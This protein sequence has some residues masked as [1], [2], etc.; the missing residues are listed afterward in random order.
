[1]F[2]GTDFVLFYSALLLSVLGKFD[3]SVLILSVRCVCTDSSLFNSAIFM[4]QLVIFVSSLLCSFREYLFDWFVFWK[5]SH[6]LFQNRFFFNCIPNYKRICFTSVRIFTRLFLME[7]N[8]FWFVRI[9]SFLFIAIRAKLFWTLFMTSKN[10]FKICFE[11]FKYLSSDFQRLYKLWFVRLI[12]NICIVWLWK[13][14]YLCEP[15]EI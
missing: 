13:L 1:M 3:Y 9:L 11:I 12:W 7:I 2:W 8:Y 6:N 4:L 14:F 10:Y 15:L 5:L